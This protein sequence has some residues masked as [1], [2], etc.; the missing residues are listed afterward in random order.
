[1]GVAGST[2]TLTNTSGTTWTFDLATDALQPG[3]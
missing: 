2:V 1:V 3:A